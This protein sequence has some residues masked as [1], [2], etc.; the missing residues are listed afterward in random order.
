M[1]WTSILASTFIN[2]SHIHNC[3][4]QISSIMWFLFNLPCAV[5]LKTC[6]AWHLKTKIKHNLDQQTIYTVWTDEFTLNIVLKWTRSYRFRSV[7]SIKMFKEKM[8]AVFLNK[9][10]FHLSFSKKT[11]SRA[12]RLPKSWLPIKMSQADD[13]CA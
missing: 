5:S 12:W 8:Y 13:A 2:I 6:F 7:I 4:N 9:T 10:A 1:F 11:W 3:L